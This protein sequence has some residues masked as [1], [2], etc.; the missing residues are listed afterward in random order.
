VFDLNR[1]RVACYCR[2]STDKSEQLDSLEKQIGFFNDLVNQGDYELY[3]LYADEGI[4]GKQAKKRPQFLQ[5]MNDARSHKF[6]SI[7]VKDISRLSRNTVDFLNCIRE[8]KSIGI[9]I[10]FTNINM[11]I[12]ECSEFMLTIFASLAQEESKNLSS[13]VKFGKKINAA[14]GRVPNF[15]FGYNRI[16][17]FTLEI[18]EIE[19][20][21]VRYIF[22]M[23]VK[24]GNGEAKIANELNNQNI[25]TKKNRTKW[26]QKTIGD[27]L[28]NQLYIG[29]IINHKSEVV[30][31]LTGKRKTIAADMQLTVEKPNLQIIDDE[32]FEKAQRI[33]KNRGEMFSMS[34][35]GKARP[36][37]KYPLSNLIKCSECGFSFRRCH[38][39]YSDNGKE[40]IWWTCSYRN[41][42]GVDQCINDI[43]IYEQD[44]HN[45]LTSFFNTLFSFREDM[46]KVIAEEI[47][48][49]VE[50]NNKN[51]SDDIVSLKSE[52]AK[53]MKEKTKYM[54]M[55]KNDVIDM[56]ELKSYTDGINTYLYNIETKINMIESSNVMNLNTQLVIKNYFN[57]LERAINEAGLE[58]SL[59][60]EIIDK[61]LVYPTGE[62]K[63]Y[64]KLDEKSKVSL[65]LPLD[66]FIIPM[67]SEVSI[68]PECNVKT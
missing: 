12:E 9:N 65:E 25:L 15:V 40:Y 38:R 3:K 18:N 39:K 10:Y 32:T 23:Y 57:N 13:R 4:S 1:Q 60:K 2:V 61:I 58:N 35:K 6:E 26:S 37:N 28:K 27:I 24:M 8:L 59:L 68:V 54:D 30:D 29:K 34:F 19:A 46:E 66:E 67:S 17:T 41:T 63:V 55:Y 22:D 31:F 36:S 11:N 51:Y 62:I 49:L 45:A 5:M 14:K 48:H 21:T 43:K 44:I 52:Q 7:L 33:L 64:L 50:E 53:L 20:N 42:Y 47:N 16:D 56:L